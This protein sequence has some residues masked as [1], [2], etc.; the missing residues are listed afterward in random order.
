MS[1]V[2]LERRPIFSDMSECE[3]QEYLQEYIKE[4]PE[5]SK[6]DAIS[7]IYIDLW[8]T[9][10]RYDPG[11]ADYAT[12]AYN[13]GRHVIKTILTQ[14]TKTRRIREKFNSFPNFRPSAPSGYDI[15]ERDDQLQHAF[16]RMTKEEKDVATMRYYDDK[17]VNEIAETK[18]CSPQKIYQILSGL[19]RLSEA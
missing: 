6:D 18:S 14:V 3:A 10:G 2:Q 11:I 5:H 19:K 13:R 15:A 4:N 7:E 12:Y 17:T 8:N 9:R 16:E 1:K